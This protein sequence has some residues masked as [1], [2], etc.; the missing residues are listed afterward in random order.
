[1]ARIIFFIQSKK[2]PAGI[3]VRLRDGVRI[4][5]KA[6]T[7]FIIDPKDWSAP[8]NQPKNGEAHLKKLSDDLNKLQS[9]LLSFYNANSDK[10]AI[11]SKWLKDFINP[12]KSNEEKSNKLL[13]YFNY[14]ITIKKNEIGSGS[15]KKLNVIMALLKRFE[16][17]TKTEYL[18][19]NIDSDFKTK[20]TTYCTEQNYASNTISRAVKYIKTIC[21]HARTNGITTNPQLD[22]IAHKY[23]KTEKIYL[24]T[25]ELK[26]IEETVL[27]DENLLIARDW[28]L[29]SCE[30]GQRVSDFM[31][32]KKD[33]IR[34][35]GTHSLIEF[36][37]VKT[38]KIMTVPLSTRVLEIL[39][40]RKGEF[41]KALSDQKYNGFIKQVCRTAKLN[42]M[43]EGNIINVENKIKRNKSGIFPKWQLVTS[44]IGR[45]SFATNNYGR[46]P[47]SLLIGATGHS[48]EKQFLEYIGK[49]DSQKAIQLAAYF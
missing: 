49:S 8:K 10:Q 48:T 24:T 42:E 35:D 44:H 30:T 41:P 21:Y 29:I 20:F 17:E 3:Y 23:Q 12:P 19:A 11:N 39:K 7:N 9:N 37:Q 15:F 2:N 5:A 28:L 33:M 34:I 43:I 18:M 27:E 6:K 38:S 4:D 1:M 13:E 40:K 32:F 22:H 14:Y 36:T 26:V 31:R 47:T 45:R 46:V 16:K 25:E